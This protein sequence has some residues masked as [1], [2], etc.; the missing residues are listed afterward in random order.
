MSELE[1]VYGSVKN[2]DAPDAVKQ[3]ESVTQSVAPPDTH[4]IILLEQ[5]VSFLEQRLAAAQEQT[6]KAESRETEARDE[7]KRLLGIIEH[8]T[9]LIEAPKEPEKQT[10]FF[11][12]LFG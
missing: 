8:Q 12:R 7:A 4:K 10:G 6:R 1:R 9:R 5:Q 11:K 2:P 3:G